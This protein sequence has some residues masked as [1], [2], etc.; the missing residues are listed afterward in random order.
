MRI[1]FF[2]PTC[3]QPLSADGFYSGN[4]IVCPTCKES[5]SIPEE[6][7]CAADSLPTPDVP[8]SSKLD[9]RSSLRRQ[10]R[11][12]RV[13][14]AVSLLLLF[15]AI[16]AAFPTAYLANAFHTRSGAWG[17]TPQQTATGPQTPPAD[18][19][20][21]ALQGKEGEASR[22]GE[23][24]PTSTSED[25]L[26][27]DGMEDDQPPPAPAKAEPAKPPLAQ[28]TLTTEPRPQPAPP[29]QDTAQPVAKPQPPQ[30]EKRVTG[31]VRQRWANNRRSRLTDV[32]LRAQL[33]QP[34]EVDL[35]SVPGTIQRVIA[36]SG[37]LARTG[38]DVIPPLAAQR[39]DLFG[40]PF[41]ESSLTR[42]GPEEAI[43]LKVLAQRLRSQV[44]ASIPGKVYGVIDPRPDAN[45]L[46]QRLLANPQ[47]VLWLRP[48][49]IATLRQLLMH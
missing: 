23:T 13:I 5:L 12:R 47:A 34:P 27:P 45:L 43:N 8:S 4:E 25:P 9:R 19:L 10:R 40:L 33:L 21:S 24:H 6:E 46:R 11:W 41:H 32:E 2:C 14:A 35:E 16:G 18:K 31:T 48:Q 28:A 1:H 22:V 30:A 29:N 15:L 17:G 38:I 42:I 49:A 20:V 44:Q 26:E 36:I 39:S 37:R 7:S 3:H